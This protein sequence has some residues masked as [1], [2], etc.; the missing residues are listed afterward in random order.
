VALPA[1]RA[2]AEHALAVER[3]DEARELAAALL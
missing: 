2:A 3:P 1:A